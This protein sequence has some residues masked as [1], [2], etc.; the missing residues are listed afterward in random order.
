[1]GMAGEREEEGKYID[2]IKY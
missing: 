1:M 2:K